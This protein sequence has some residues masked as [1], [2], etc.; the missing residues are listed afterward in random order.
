[1]RNERRSLEGFLAALL[2]QSRSPDEVVICDG[3]STDG[4]LESLEEL[5]ANDPRF[6][7]LS[8]PGAT[9]ARGRNVAIQ[10]AQGP[11]IAVTDAGTLADPTWLERLV[12]PLEG[13]PSVQ[14]SAG[15]FLAGGTT[16]LERTLSTVI[17]PQLAEIDP[18]QFL[19]S[20]RSIAFRKEA[21][22]GVGGYPEWLR[23]CEDLVFD[24]DLKRVGARFTFTPDAVVTWH[25]RPQLGA[26]FRQYFN[27]ARGDGHARLWPRRHAARY[28]A[29]SLGIGL[30]AL[31]FRSRPSR[32]ILATGMAY[33]FGPY[34]RRVV[35]QPVS[36]KVVDQLAALALAPAIVVTGDVAK[37][38]G[39]PV[40]CF[41]R[42]TGRIR[43][44]LDPFNVG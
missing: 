5:A 30:V 1:M 39:Y 9:I 29:Y 10:Q 8:A 34:V 42:A 41:E 13:N 43:P 33:H 14:V 37:M 40:G 3:G 24:L 22:S 16:W 44:A 7:V 27:Y 38:L 23:H 4:T 19:P 25:A 17:T 6:T 18:G 12:S 26:F 36:T 21:W 35:R 15:F 2:A 20:S 32:A 11:L 28:G 31:A